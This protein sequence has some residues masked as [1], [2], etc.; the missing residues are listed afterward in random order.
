MTKQSRLR[1]HNKK[2]G[3]RILLYFALVAAAG[4]AGWF[5]EQKYLLF[6]SFKDTY[7]SISKTPPRRGEFFDRNLRQLAVNKERVSVY[8]RTQ[9]IDS[10][11]KTVMELAPILS[12]D[13]AKLKAQLES[14]A[15][16]LWIAEDISQDQEIA[17]KAKQ[18][19]GVFLQ[20][21][22][23]RV[24]PNNAQAAHLIGFV[25]NG[26]GLAGVE[27]YYDRLLATGQL[28]HDEEGH[29][30]SSQDLVLTLD[31]K[32]QDVL[33]GLV[34]EIR[35]YR[36]TTNKVLAYVMESRTGAVIGGAQF[37]GFD[38]NSFIQYPQAVLESQF[39]TSIL[40]PD[41]FRLFLRDAAI[42]QGKKEGLSSFIPWSLRSSENIL[43][44][45]L[46]LWDW[47]GLNN[48]TV[49]DFRSSAQPGEIVRSDQRPVV[50]PPPFL[51]MVPEQ[52]TPL[53]LLKAITVI[54]NNGE[55]IRPFV[56]QKSLD[57]ETGA[58]VLLVGQE[59]EEK[60]E[61]PRT[62]FNFAGLKELF[63][64]QARQGEGKSHFFS[65]TIVSATN[66]DGHQNIQVNELLLATIPAGGSDLS[67]LVVVGHD[68][69]EP[70]PRND[71]LN[72]TLDEIVEEKVERISVLQQVAQ[73]VADVVEAELSE[74][75]NYQGQKRIT[76]KTQG[77][78]D[79][80]SQV[81]AIMPDLHGLSLRKSLRLMQGIP[82]KISIQGTGKVV[83]QKPLPGTPLK[84][85]AES[86][87]VLENGEE[88][89]LEKLSKH[90]ALKK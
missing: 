73:S 48:K 60:Q 20:R 90:A 47:L 8:V 65:D 24:Y 72:K 89:T 40:L 71:M 33:D 37:P 29:F 27:Y 23:K 3:R 9:E 28:R 38:P 4:V 31:L 36:N 44:S 5:V 50:S 7:T 78:K 64:S 13:E 56:V 51:E 74:D 88:M 61:S 66:K 58:E 53:N 80:E 10:I 76:R 70:R 14:G 57:L 22:E 84:G 49:T 26:I 42:L 21:E 41:K 45:Q 77:K 43:G 62:P 34:E 1:V 87:L 54:L 55:M 12:L 46:Q 81:A 79:T 11:E 85:I 82:V 52:T 69:L 15:L 68:P 32:I 2:R 6:T 16:R 75:G 86:T 63:Y 83:S 25:E 18:L 17:I 19:S 59:P 35:K 39:V 67:M 30:S